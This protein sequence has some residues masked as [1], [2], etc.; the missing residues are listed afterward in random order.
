MTIISKRWLRRRKACSNGWLAIMRE[1]WPDGAPATLET[2]QAAHAA[3]VPPEDILWVAI[4]LLG[5]KRDRQQFI[6]FTLKQRQPYLVKLFKRA[7]LPDHADAIEALT[8]ADLAEARQ[9]LDAA[10][11]AARAAWDAARAAARDARWAAGDAN[12]AATRDAAW[13]A[14]RDAAWTASYDAAIWEQIEWIAQRQEAG[15]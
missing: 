5:R 13:T 14:A 6:L 10:W 15:A 4:R 12:D 1:H 8:W 3:G 7:K 11:A 2:A 9:V